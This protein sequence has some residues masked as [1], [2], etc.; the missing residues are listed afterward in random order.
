MKTGEILFLQTHLDFCAEGYP[1]EIITFF[2]VFLASKHLHE[3]KKGHPANR[4][5]YKVKLTFKNYL[6]QFKYR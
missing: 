3:P 1:S 2:T 4:N 5:A 6:E